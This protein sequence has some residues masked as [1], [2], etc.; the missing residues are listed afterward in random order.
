VCNLMFAG[1][2]DFELEAIVAVREGRTRVG[3]GRD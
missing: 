3:K 1:K 2:R